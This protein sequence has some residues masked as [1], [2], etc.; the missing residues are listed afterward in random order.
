MLKN[1]DQ[2]RNG[3]AVMTLSARL[4]SRRASWVSRSWPY[5]AVGLGYVVL[6]L[7]AVWPL[8]AQ[9]TTA[10]PG[11]A[12]QHADFAVFHWNIWWFQHAIF[13]LGRDPYFT[14]YILFPHNINLA[15]HTFTPLLDVLALPIYATLGLTAALNSWIVGSLVFNSLAMFAFLRHHRVS[16]GLAFLGGTLYA[17]ASATMSRVSFVHLSMTPNGWLPL[18]LLAWDWLIER[19]RWPWAVLLGIVLY[20]TLLTDIQ[21]IVW[22]AIL[23]PLYAL[24]T[25]FQVERSERQ[26]IVALGVLA[27]VI[28]AGLS[29]IAPLRQ[30]I[31]G[32]DAQYGEEY[33]GIIEDW[34]STH[35]EDLIAFPPRY[36][37]NERATLGVLLPLGLA[38]GLIAGRKVQGRWFWL[39]VGLLFLVLALGPTL[40]PLGIPLPFRLFYALTGGTYRVAARFLLPAVMCFV[41]FAALSL[42]PWYQRLGRLGSI[43]LVSGALIFLAIENH[44][45]ESLPVFTMPDYSIYHQIGAEPGE[46]LILEVPVGPHNLFRGVFGKGGV[47]QYYAPIHHKQ[48]ING[49]VSRAPEG[50]TQSYRQWPLIAALAEEA[51]MPDLSAARAEFARLSDEWNM[52]YV[53]IHRDMLESESATFA[54]GLLNTQAGWCFAGEEGPILIYTRRGHVAC[55]EPDQ[56][57]LP[58][59]EKID[60]GSDH[61]RYL[62]PGWYYTEDIGG[63]AARWMGR[64]V[65]TTLR[66]NLPVRDY[67]VKMTATTIVPDQ[68][69]SVYVNHRRVADLPIGGGWNDYTFDLPVATI[70][71]DQPT[72]IELVPAKRLSPQELTTGQSGDQRLLAAAIS[73]LYFEAR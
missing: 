26:R 63:S 28:F 41:V 6:T 39:A 52:Q 3:A 1:N 12:G 4:N 42:Q 22:L 69:L 47:L 40:K 34:Y 48:L 73:A 17:F 29:L 35:L 8:M 27:I 38:V 20:A 5:L 67:R 50:L 31:A 54:A 9:F 14:N 66:M 55:A 64:E 36:L 71:T 18:S 10:T 68:I 23:L 25:L 72:T 46:F 7:L 70:S 2:A 21:F 65:T 53:L 30:L 61:E 37:V 43:G 19:R 13:Q 32:M 51:P 24:Y 44:W 15:Y 49:A 60:L 33:Q 45:Y 62:G 56:L 57:N 11:I 16:T 59:D 58:P